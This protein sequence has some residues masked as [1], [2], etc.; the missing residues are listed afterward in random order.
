[1][2]VFVL[3]DSG[4]ESVLLCRLESVSLYRVSLFILNQL[5]LSGCIE[6]VLLYRSR[7]IPGGVTSGI[8]I[9]FCVCLFVL[10]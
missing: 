9:L 5:G 2:L 7:V 6:S 1:M 3:S 10:F 4:I 8:T